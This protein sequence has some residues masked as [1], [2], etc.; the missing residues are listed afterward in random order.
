MVLVEN[1]LGMRQ[2]EVI[3]GVF[4]PRQ[5]YQRL[6]IVELDRVVWA[7]RMDVVEFGQ[8]FLENLLGCLVPFLG[9]RLFEQLLLFRTAFAFAQ[10]FLD[11]LDLLLQVIFLL[12]FVEIKLRLV[13]D[14]ILQV[15]QFLLLVQGLERL[16][17][18][19]RQLLLLQHLDLVFCRKRQGGADEVAF[20]EAIGNLIDC[21]DSLVGNVLIVLNEFDRFLEECLG[22]CLEH[23][24]L[25][26]LFGR[27]GL[28]QTFYIGKVEWFLIYNLLHLASA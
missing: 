23:R 27:P 21:I 2:A 3:L 8:L 9:L 13:S 22:Q 25:G 7:L 17:Q 20:H 24:V 6:Q 14:F 15:E 26:F 19:F 12:L 4:A 28:W 1:L 16:Y 5:I 11:V 10:L 18:S